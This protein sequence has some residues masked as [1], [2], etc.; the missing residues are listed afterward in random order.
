MLNKYLKILI[1]QTNDI[2]RY[3]MCIKKEVNSPI[4]LLFFIIINVTSN[5]RTLCNNDFCR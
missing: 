2:Q 1:L 4:E 3:F 5:K